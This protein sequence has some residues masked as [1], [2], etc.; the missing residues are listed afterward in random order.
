MKA[1]PWW[2]LKEWSGMH[3]PK[4]CSLGVLNVSLG[5]RHLK[6]S[7]R[8]HRLSESFNLSKNQASSKR[9]TSVTDTLPGS[10]INQGEL[11][12]TEEGTKSYTKPN[13]L[14][15]TITPPSVLPGPRSSPLKITC[16]L[17]Q[18]RI[19]P[20]LPLLKQYINLNH[21][22]LFYF[23]LWCLEHIVLKINKLHTFFTCCKFIL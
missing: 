9:N 21:T 8:R 14:W 3:R 11:T 15:Q 12:F 7:K 20:P 23:F 22:A 16:S 4:G 6:S 10:F 2:L 19:L 5:W 18:W 17:S 13:R 1:S